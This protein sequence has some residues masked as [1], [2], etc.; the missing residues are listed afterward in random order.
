MEGKILIIDDDDLVTISLKKILVKLGYEVLICN[1]PDDYEEIIRINE[2][3]VILLDIFF[4]NHNGLD[5]LK[6]IQVNNFQI[7]VIMIT[8]YSDVKIAIAAM[9]SGAFDFLLKPLDLAQLQIVL[10]KA[11]NNIYLRTEVDKY[12]QIFSEDK[13]TPGFFGKSPT[14]KKILKSVERLAK[15]PDTTILIEGE[16]GSGKE[17]FSK[18]YSSKQPQS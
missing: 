4:S 13:L 6:Q 8:G 5:L 18:I 2:P 14:I 12:Q 17:M 9:K 15:S 7:P 16:S 11:F 1:N 10:N 3:D